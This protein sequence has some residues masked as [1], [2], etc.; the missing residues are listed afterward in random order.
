MPIYEQ[1]KKL[2][3][4]GDNTQAVLMFEQFKHFL[5]PSAKSEINELL[6]LAVA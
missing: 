5:T 4:T 2:V 3:T 1:I 6:E